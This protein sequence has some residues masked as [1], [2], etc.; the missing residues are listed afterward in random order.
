MILKGR[1]YTPQDMIQIGMAFFLLGVFVNMVG[2]GR[3]IGALIGNL[4]SDKSTLDTIQS[5]AAGF[6][7]PIFCASIYFNLRGL[8][9]IRSRK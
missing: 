1:K 4:I 2:D 9:V 7:I 5:V 6:S 3:M 8:I